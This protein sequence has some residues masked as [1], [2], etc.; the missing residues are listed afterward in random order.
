M[1]GSEKLVEKYIYNFIKKKY[2]A[3]L[4]EDFYLKFII[5]LLA[6]SKRATRQNLQTIPKILKKLLEH[7]INQSQQKS[8]PKKVCIVPQKCKKAKTSY[9]SYS[10]EFDSEASKITG[11]NLNS[12]NL[13]LKKRN[14]QVERK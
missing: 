11:L 13:Y 12:K 5:R 1:W 8:S 6:S 14:V 2:I 7:Q 9:G 3:C 10:T 4:Q